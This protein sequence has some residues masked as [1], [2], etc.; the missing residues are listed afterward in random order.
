MQVGVVAE[1]SQEGVL[2]VARRRMQDW[3]MLWG[4]VLVEEEDMFW[5]GMKSG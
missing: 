3:Q 5:V 4:I 2:E 1:A